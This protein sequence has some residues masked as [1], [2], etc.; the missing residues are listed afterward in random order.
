MV[1]R[2]KTN[3]IKYIAVFVLLSSLVLA[4][5][6]SDSDKD[7]MSHGSNSSGKGAEN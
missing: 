2:P 7:E 3:T 5:C 1:H 4:G 6:S